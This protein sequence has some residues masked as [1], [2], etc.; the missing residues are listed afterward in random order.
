MPDTPTAEVVPLFITVPDAAALLGISE[1]A[2]WRLVKDKKIV[3]AKI[4]RSRRVSLQ[5]L[6]DYHDQVLAD[7]AAGESA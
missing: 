7:T 2:C 4:G 1:T 5:A 3:S 6:R